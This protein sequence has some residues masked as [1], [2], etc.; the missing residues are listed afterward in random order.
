[1]I[2]PFTMMQSVEKEDI[3]C[4]FAITEALVTGIRSSESYH[5]HSF[6]ELFAVS[7]GR[8]RLIADQEHI[9]LRP[10]DVCIIPPNVT[11]YVYEETGAFRVGFLFDFLAEQEPSVV[12]IALD[13]PMY[14]GIS[15]VWPAAAPVTESM[16]QLIA[17]VKKQANIPL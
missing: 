9:V 14:T 13:P 6:Y 5:F 4:N 16:R 1:M 15:L 2:F 3:L 10:G 12:G 7:S 8:M 11:H 17:F